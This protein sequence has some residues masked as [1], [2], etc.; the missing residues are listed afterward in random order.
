MGG[1]GERDEAKHYGRRTTGRGRSIPLY[2]F[3]RESRGARQA[4]LMLW[5]RASAAREP[6]RHLVE[7]HLHHLHGDHRDNHGPLEVVA[8]ASR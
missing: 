3:E 5:S 8:S 1:S 6:C 4:W 7:G 2:C